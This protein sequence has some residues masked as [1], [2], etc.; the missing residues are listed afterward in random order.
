[1]AS[2]LSLPDEL[3]LGILA[4]LQFTSSGSLYN[5]LFSCTRL[6][7]IAKPLLYQHVCFSETYFDPDSPLFKFSSQSLPMLL[8][9]SFRLITSL[10]NNHLPDKYKPVCDMLSSAIKL[11]TFSLR[12]TSYNMLDS[13]GNLIDHAPT[14]FSAGA[15]DR[16]INALPH[17]LSNLD[18]DTAG[19][20]AVGDFPHLCHSISELIPHLRILRLRIRRYCMDLM[21][22]LTPQN[23]S[24]LE[25]A[26]I[27][28]DG[29]TD[30]RKP[31][32]HRAIDCSGDH[33]IRSGRGWFRTPYLSTS[34]LAR[35]FRQLYME[36]ALPHLS[37]FLLV[38]DGRGSIRVPGSHDYFRVHNICTNTTLTFPAN[39]YG[40]TCTGYEMIGNA[41]PR[42]IFTN[43]YWLRDLDGKQLKGDSE[44][45]ANFLEGT[46]GWKIMGNGSC[47]PPP[48]GQA[49]V[50]EY[51]PDLSCLSVLHREVDNM[52]KILRPA[53]SEL[54]IREE[55]IG[56][57]LIRATKS[58]GVEDDAFMRESLPSGWEYYRAF[59]ENDWCVRRV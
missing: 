46:L 31:W 24:R 4:N 51:C 34:K 30:G 47:L 17:T 27:H 54:W 25:A 45:V 56:K 44:E 35:G 26:T 6:H 57:D 36:G 29:N 14:P 41:P 15:V 39:L 33:A 13:E 53:L 9:N 50:L 8:T 48:S 19:M 1:M 16:F 43:V 23:P 10:H 42:E 28:L 32:F 55:T 58:E 12:L 7:H 59:L 2:I 49:S 11:R 20:Q 38:D 40:S 52:E 5:V 21:R 3:L 37:N 22:R 18:I